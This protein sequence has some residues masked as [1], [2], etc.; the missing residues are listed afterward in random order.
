MKVEISP[1]AI[2]SLEEIIV[3]L[4][5][6]WTKKEIDTL[7]KDIQ[8]FIKIMNQETITHQSLENFPQIRF[9]LIAKRQVKLFYEVRE[10]KALI[11]LFWHCKQNPKKLTDLLK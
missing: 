11:K 1:T 9:A 10:N 4:R 6:R 7:K 5:K 2:V 8:D 3:Y